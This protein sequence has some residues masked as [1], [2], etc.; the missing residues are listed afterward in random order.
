MLSLQLLITSCPPTP[1]PLPPRSYRARPAA[2]GG[3]RRFPRGLS[4]GGFRAPALQSPLPMA[5][6]N[7]PGLRAPSLPGAARRHLGPGAAARARHL[8][9]LLAP[10]QPG[11]SGPGTANRPGSDPG[12]TGGMEPRPHSP[13]HTDLD[14]GPAGSSTLK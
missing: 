11:L 14:L 2:A 12:G 10:G 3:R 1:P 8:V 13:H 6:G 5:P 9:E 4:S 7:P